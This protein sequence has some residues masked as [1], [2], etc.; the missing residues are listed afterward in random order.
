MA[1]NRL[2]VLLASNMYAYSG[3]WDKLDA[4]GR[5]VDLAV[6]TPERWGMPELGQV[7]EV[8]EKSSP[9]PWRQYRLPARVYEKGN[10][11]RFFYN[12]DPLVQVIEREK[13]DI[14]HVEQEPES[15]NLLQFSL[16][17]VRH[18][19]PLVFVAW[20]DHNPLRL[21]W[22]FRKANYALADAGIFGNQVA[23][24]RA[25]KFGFRKKMEVI[26]QYGF[27]ITAGT[28][29]VDMAGPDGHA[30]VGDGK[31]VVGYA[32]RLVPEKGV[33]TLIEATRRMPGTEVLVAGEGPL[34]SAIRE[35]PHVK[36]LG[37]VPRT[38]MAGFWSQL[39]VMVLPSLTDGKKWVE[40]FGRV[41]VEAM[42]A[43]V[44]VVGSDA[45]RIPDTVGD[46][47]LIFHEGDA[48]GLREALDTLRTS[49]ERRKALRERGLARVRD[50]YSH[51]VLMGRTVRFYEEVLASRRGAARSATS[52]GGSTQPET[53]QT[54]R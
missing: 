39:D 47:G 34:A 37:W 25:V 2:K 43:G 27:E 9:A 3:N 49:P 52:I 53:G 41:L 4:L 54:E 14:V 30:R 45:G 31:F 10:P 36:M 11:F 42:A 22:G 26:P 21:G 48:A 17:K 38:E 8:P 15:I 5:F 12:W 44:P 40:Q 23:M 28:F 16:L 1:A 18:R 6:I 20:E 32:G 33:Q 29:G 19:F 50:R 7:L 13:P 35:E 46:A 24:E 51:D